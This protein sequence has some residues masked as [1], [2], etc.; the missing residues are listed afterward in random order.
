MK[1]EIPD[2]CL[3]VLMGASSSGKSTFARR[4]FRNTEVISSDYCRATVAD[5]E[6][7][8]D[9]NT[10]TFELL[11]FIVEKRLKRGLLTVVDATN[12]QT[13]ARQLLVA[14]ARKYHV[15]AIGIALNLP[16]QILLQRNEIR[17]DRQL[18]PHVLRNHRRQMKS[19]FRL[20]K[21]EGFHRFYELKTEEQIAALSIERK[22]IWSNKKE[23]QGPFDIIG[24]VH[25]CF[26]E[27]R[28]LLTLLGYRI[29]RHRDRLRNWGYTVKAPEGRTAIFV[30]DLVDRGPASNEVLRL[31]MSMQEAGNALVVC[32]NHDDKLLR[33][34]Q[35]RNVQ[36][37]HGLEQTLAQLEDESPEFLEAVPSFLRG[38]ISHYVLDEGR[39]VVAHAGLGEAM[40]GRTSKA[41]RAFCLYGETS[42]EIDEFGLPVR[43]NWARDY[44]GKALV[45]YGHTPVT[46]A[47]WY[48]NTI[49]I[50][51]GCVFGGQLTALRYPEREMISVPAAQEYA[52][53]ARPLQE[54]K[55]T[56]LEEDK[57]Q[58]P[59]LEDVLGKRSIETGLHGVVTIREEN[60]I[61]ALEIMSRFAVNPKWLI[62]LPPTMSPVETAAAE[63]YLE[64]PLETF[65]YFRN[66]GIRQVVCQEKHMGSRA[67][68]V[69]GRDESV[70]ARR[71]G[72]QGEG[73]GTIYTRTGRAFFSEKALEQELLERLRQAMD[74]SGFWEKL[75]TDWV[76][77]DAELMP[78]SAKAK[79][80]LQNQYAAVGAS[81]QLALHHSRQALQRAEARGLNTGTLMTKLESA[82]NRLTRFQDAY[83]QYCWETEKPEDYRLAPF[84][85]LATETA[86]HTDRDHLWHMQQLA[87]FCQNDPFLLATQYQVVDL[88]DPDVIQQATDWW[89]ELTQKG[90]EGMVVKPLDFINRHQ[91][92][93]VQPAV[94]CRGREYL[95]IIYGPDYTVSEQ[96]AR[97]KRRGLSRKRSLALREFA[98]GMKALEH[99]VRRDA[100]SR[101]HESVFG[102]LA[103][104]SEPVDP[105]L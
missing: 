88:D 65:D 52:Q 42:G 76:L 97:L 44:R 21:K 40:Q 19:S 9:A 51:T 49:D 56:A 99:F 62:Y 101:V 48:N 71:F 29:T 96:L 32:G 39:L 3:V 4:H 98:L 23:L 7:A 25:G 28:E 41:V 34:L 80:L 26:D 74:E 81:G 79:A 70:I 11:H 43:Y 37:K 54:V 20:L 18:R 68:V 103:L 84:H 5:D 102:V 24:D 77:L 1:I 93:L 58:L 50:D 14:L 13:E 94:K 69:L 83:R 105:A 92:R 86:V 35:G 60:A 85:L 36:I 53:S 104:E 90:G 63:N 47:Q 16:E 8:M 55:T 75:Q 15:F 95:R 57:D 91:G 22:K 89:L 10:D 12:V 82:Q 38:L 73:I 27:L 78:W 30:G 72:I 45:V 6:N 67:V 61:A 46:E 66:Q 33:K 100:F 17:P 2:L 87:D 59:D 31:V 64:H